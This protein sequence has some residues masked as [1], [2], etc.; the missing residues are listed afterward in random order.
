MRWTIS[1]IPAKAQQEYDA[2]TKSDKRQRTS[3]MLAQAEMVYFEIGDPAR[4]RELLVAAL[5]D[6]SVNGRERFQTLSKCAQ[7]ALSQGRR[8]KALQ[9]YAMLE[10]LP[11]E[12]ANDRARYL[13]Q[14]WYEMGRIEASCGHTAAAKTLFR[15][16]M[17]LQDGEMRFRVRA[18]DALESI[19]YFE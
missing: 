5:M 4:G 2:V 13:S 8:D 16:A 14:T 12:K 17:E 1:Q 11:F 7:D 10:K 9:W 6:R 3:G 19:E 18:R 15:N